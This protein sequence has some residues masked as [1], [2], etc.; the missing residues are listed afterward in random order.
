MKHNKIN[1]Q[2]YW[3]AFCV[4]YRKGT[5]TISYQSKIDDLSPYRNIYTKLTNM[6][7]DEGARST[8]KYIKKLRVLVYKIIGQEQF[9]VS[10]MK[11]D[12]ATGLPAIL[13]PQIGRAL[14]VRDQFTIRMLLSLL[15]VS[16]I[17]TDGKL[18]PEIETIT[19]PSEADDDL[20]AKITKYASDNM[21]E[22]FP[23]AEILPDW[24]DPHES[25]SAGPLGPAVW[26]I[27]EE[28]DL[29]SEDMISH[30]S[31]LGGEALEEY[32]LNCYNNRDLLRRTHEF[33]A[34][35]QGKPARGANRNNL[36]RLAAIPAP[37]CKTRIIAILDWWTQTALKPIHQWSFD[38]L[39]TI[40][41]DMT[42]NQ[43]GFIKVLPKTGP[44]YSF[45]L[46]A[47]TDRFPISLQEN[48]L[49]LLIGERKARAWRGLLTGHRFST[50]WNAEYYSYSAGQP[51][52]AYSSWSVFTLCHHLIVQYSASQCGFPHG[53][54]RDYC[55]LG[56]DIVIANS[57]VAG[58]YK[59][60]IKG[61]GV[62]ISKEKSLV[63][64]DTYEF[65]KRLV[66]QGQELTA[67][68]LAAIV[69][70]S[71]SVTA[72]WATT[73]VAR[74]RGFTF[75]TIYSNP[76][77]VA[78]FQRAC[79]LII[80]ETERIARE[81]DA[82]HSIT[83]QTDEESF[84]WGLFQVIKFFRMS[85]P[86]TTDIEELTHFL[87]IE[88]GGCIVKYQST[89]LNET[90]TRYLDL[91]RLI[92]E[93]FIE[94]LQKE[95]DSGQGTTSQMATTT[96]AR[97]YPLLRLMGLATLRAMQESNE[98]R[99]VLSE[100]PSIDFIRL[101]VTPVGD[102]SRVISRMVNVKATARQAAFLRFLRT[103][104]SLMA[105]RRKRAL[106]GDF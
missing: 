11:T 58:Y 7:R 66:C 19:S 38:L 78:E 32:L 20:V 76:G 65:A 62:G 18:I 81:L 50:S 36:R 96:L 10:F 94:F 27:P 33:L 4:L 30:I 23:H 44:Y 25:T 5:E 64:L 104:V 47:A 52:G 93:N 89:L 14:L 60:V 13:G 21:K 88:L 106:R 2:S 91:R 40:K 3:N 80:R 67:F 49:S 54:F 69:E 45:D 97:D 86:C 56:D 68:P 16:Y 85:A 71:K 73:L 34:D 63:S 99:R 6:I 55:I 43:D 1:T 8:V 98:L 48:F 74:D 77:I 95:A 12:K 84:N 59:D 17:I 87:A 79:G 24:T 46:S 42:F 57:L 100:G 53:K 41:C 101:T 51:M 29:L 72:L 75:L 28:L 61:L 37:E 15:Q 83:H 102:L 35:K 31:A 26:T 22:L 9:D 90:T 103:E 70:N 105:E 82:L 39:R 92:T